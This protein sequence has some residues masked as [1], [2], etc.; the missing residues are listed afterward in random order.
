MSKRKNIRK[1]QDTLWKKVITATDYLEIPEYEKRKNVTRGLI[2]PVNL[3]NK[4]HILSSPE[5]YHQPFYK[6]PEK[7]SRTRV[8]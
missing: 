3:I 2:K 5:D 7:I 1:I 4:N 8:P 6:H